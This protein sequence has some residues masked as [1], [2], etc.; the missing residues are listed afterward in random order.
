MFTS[1]LP[2]VLLCQG[3]GEYAKT[4]GWAPFN[5]LMCRKPRHSE[6][7]A[8][9]I[10]IKTQFEKYVDKLAPTIDEQSL[11]YSVNFMFQVCS[12]DHNPKPRIR[13]HGNLNSKSNESP[14]INSHTGLKVKSNKI[15]PESS[16]NA[17]YLMQTLQIGSKK[18]LIFFDSGANMHLCK[19]DMAIDENF[20]LISRKPTSL[21]VVGG[22]QIRTEH[23]VYRFNLGPTVKDEYLEIN[24]IGIDSITTKFKKYDL[25]HIRSEYLNHNNLPN[26]TEALPEYSGGTDVDLL[27]GMK[28]INVQPTLLQVLPSGIGV[29]RSVFKDIWGSQIIFAGP[30]TSFTSTNLGSKEESSLAIFTVREE[31]LGFNEL[32]KID[33]QGFHSTVIDP[34]Y[35]ISIY[36]TPMTPDDILD[37][38]GE[39]IPDS[40]D[41]LDSKNRV[42]P[43]INKVCQSKFCGAHKAA[44]PILD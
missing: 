22:S 28:N 23:G 38:G 17:F 26:P 39:I 30:H 27:L 44:I 3:C 31:D 34:I 19:G 8:P 14:C 13:D 36:P 1:T 15:V 33:V 10:D 9:F 37:M 20:K 12:V 40:L 32:S 16:E 4:Q 41:L 25:S 7:R 42:I 11:K 29:Y 5:I 2:E 35:D 21:T 18:R 43:S 24:C 6:T